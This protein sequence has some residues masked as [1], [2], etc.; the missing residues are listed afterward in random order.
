MSTFEMP[1]FWTHPRRRISAFTL[2]ELLV[3][4]AI[5][6][7]LVALLLP[8]VNAARNA[9]RRTQC[10]NN[11]RQLGL[12]VEMYLDS[13]G[14]EYPDV[15]LV[16][17]IG[18]APTLLEV[19]GPYMEQNQA[20]LSCPNDSSFY[21][22]DEPTDPHLSYYD[23][24]GQ[25]YEYRA[26]RLAGKNRKEIVKQRRRVWQTGPSGTA[27]RKTVETKIKLSEVLIMRDYSYF[28]GPKGQIGSRNALYADAHVETY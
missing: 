24:F 15:A 9:A 19:F 18:T 12:S 2:V 6:G 1:R 7:M 23:K 14:E 10:K 13:H 8:A 20:T 3:V 17:G 28:H 26:H 16:P 4:V 25:S 22:R 21:R 5:I 27:E 11:L